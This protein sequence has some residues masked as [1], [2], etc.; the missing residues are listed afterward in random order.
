M[1]NK[2]KQRRVSRCARLTQRASV[3]PHEG[4]GGVA[5]REEALQRQVGGDARE[6]NDS[7]AL[8]RLVL[9]R[10]HVLHP[11]HDVA[12]RLVLVGQHHLAGGRAGACGRA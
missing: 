1:R 11:H 10:R 6:R 7:G 8:R 12:V 5:P 4:D 3:C 9:V 2:A